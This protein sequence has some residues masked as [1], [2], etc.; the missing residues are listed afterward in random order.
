MVRARLRM[1]AKLISAPDLVRRQVGRGKPKAT[2]PVCERHGIRKRCG[3]CKRCKSC[4]ICAC[5]PPAI[6][7]RLEEAFLY[8]DEY[9]EAIPSLSKSVRPAPRVRSS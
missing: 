9:N 6:G 3:K 5:A 7:A 8:K 1:R 2:G 4:R